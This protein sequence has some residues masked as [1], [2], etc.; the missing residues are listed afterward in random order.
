MV[1]QQPA[2]LTVTPV[3]VVWPS[4]CANVNQVRCP[5]GKSVAIVATPSH[6]VVSEVCQ[7]AQIVLGAASKQH[8]RGTNIR[9]KMITLAQVVILVPNDSAAEHDFMPKFLGALITDVIG[10]DCKISMR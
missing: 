7:F 6:F 8:G 1:G 2:V 9:M 4:S 3:K 5:H 10:A